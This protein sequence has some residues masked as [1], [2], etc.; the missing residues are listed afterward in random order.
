MQPT[1]DPKR[2]QEAVWAAMRVRSAMQELVTQ[3][4][5]FYQRFPELEGTLHARTYG[6]SVAQ[7]QDGFFGGLRILMRQLPSPVDGMETPL[8][9]ERTALPVQSMGGRVGPF[10]IQP[11][12]VP[13]G[14]T[15]ATIA[16]IDDEHV[17]LIVPC[18]TDGCT[19]RVEGIAFVGS[20]DRI[21]AN[22][23]C[24]VCHTSYRLDYQFGKNDIQVTTLVQGVN[25]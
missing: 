2:T 19:G 13:D 22:A 21:D 16:A 15:V 18:Q 4:D 11:S 8:T 20:P 14:P 6:S 23:K 9:D 10:V 17:A 1:N 12:G 24:P 3:L 25:Q 7:M 5:K